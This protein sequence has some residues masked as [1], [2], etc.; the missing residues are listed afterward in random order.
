MIPSN[1]SQ[2]QTPCL[3]LKPAKNDL[4]QPKTVKTSITIK[5]L[6]EYSDD[7]LNVIDR[8]FSTMKFEFGS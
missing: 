1:A 5:A 8:T 4:S 3:A 2:R 6:N 7:S